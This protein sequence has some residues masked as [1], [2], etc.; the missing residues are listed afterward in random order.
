[1]ATVVRGCGTRDAGGIYAECL[2]SPHGRPVEEF[3][4]DP[5]VPVDADALRITPRGVRLIPRENV[6]HVYDWVG[7]MYYPNVAD[8]VEEVKRYGVSRKLNPNLSFG[9]LTPASRL[10]LLHKRAYIDNFEEYGSRLDKSCPK[11]L[12]PHWQGKA[13]CMKLWWEDIA[14]GERIKEDERFVRRKMPGF[15][16]MGMEKP[17]GVEP[18][19]HLAIFAIFPINRI[20]IIN[21]PEGGKH[22]ESLEMASSARLPVRLVEE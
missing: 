21:D 15:E 3:L 6:V 10:V 22:E 8:F 2:L 7:E 11:G 5:P 9:R 16:Y 4:V 20:A 13:M 18:D 1:M 14:H 12:P 17:E 19:Y